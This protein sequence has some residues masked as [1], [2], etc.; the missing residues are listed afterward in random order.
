[1]T[2]RRLRPVK[3]RKPALEPQVKACRCRGKSTGE[4]FWNDGKPA[5]I[6]VGWLCGLRCVMVCDKC[7][8][9]WR[10]A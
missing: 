5:I 7:G 10:K 6:A 3:N 8:K 1:M 2:P 4:F 9:K